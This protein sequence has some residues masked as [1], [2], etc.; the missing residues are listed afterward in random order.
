[1]PWRPLRRIAFAVA[2]HPFKAT[3]PADLPLVVGDELYI[4]E[5]GGKNSSWCRGYLVA[6]P[7]IVAGLTSAKGQTLE[8][9]VFSGIFPKQCVEIRE[10]MEQADGQAE[11]P[12]ALNGDL[13]KQ[14]GK[15][16]LENEQEDHELD[17]AAEDADE[18][19]SDDS[20]L[21]EPLALNGSLKSAKPTYVKTTEMEVRDMDSKRPR[22]A[23]TG[24][25]FETPRKPLPPVPLLKIG[26]ETPLLLSEPLVDEEASCLREWHSTKLHELLL[27]RRYRDLSRLGKRVQRADLCRRQLLHTVLAQP[28]ATNLRERTVWDLVNGNKLVGDEV[29]VRD[30]IQLGRL[31]TGSDDPI[32]VAK[33]QSSMSLLDKPPTQSMDVNNLHHLL[34]ELKDTASHSSDTVIMVVYIC[35]KR[36]EERMKFLSETFQFTIKTG[37][38]HTKSALAKMRTLFLNLTSLDIGE[39]A[40]PEVQV[41]LVVRIVTRTTL[42]ANP[43]TYPPSSSGDASSRP[44]SSLENDRTHS[45]KGRRSLMWSQKSPPS[46]RQKPPHIIEKGQLSASHANGPEL[47]N[48]DSTETSAPSKTQVIDKDAGI[49]VLHLTKAMLEDNHE[50]SLTVNVWSPTNNEPEHGSDQPEAIILPFLQDHLPSVSG[51]FDFAKPVDR[52]K[53]TLHSFVDPKADNLIRIRPTLLQHVHQTPKAGFSGAPT[54]P[55]SDIY[56]TLVKPNFPGQSLFAHHEKGAIP[57]PGISEMG[58]M[59]LTL[60]VRKSSGVRV[61]NC[62]FISSNASGLTAWRTTAISKHRTWSQIIKL[63]IPSEDVP[64]CHIIMSL[65]NFPEFPFALS[66][67]P[68][69]KDGAFIQDGL[70]ML[71]LHEYNKVTAGTVDTRGAYLE[72][73]WDAKSKD[74]ANRESWSSHMANLQIDTFLCSTEFSQDQVLL[75]IL[76]WKEAADDRL[77]LLLRQMV[78]V[79]EIEIV[80][81]VSDTL[82][83]LFSILVDRSGNDEFEDLVFNALVTVLSI[84]HDRRFHLD[85]LIDEYAESRFNYPFATP[86]LLRSYL[87]LIARRADYQNSRQ[88]RATL[89]VGRQIIKF[90][91]VARKQQKAKEAGIGITNN[92]AA[93]VRD[94]KKIF[95]ALEEQM[96]DESPSLIGNKTLILQHLHTWLPELLSCFSHEDIVN[97]GVSFVDACSN[98]GGKL[99]MHKLVLIW[100]FAKLAASVEPELRS[101][102]N[103]K[104][105]EWLDPYWGGAMEPDEQYREQVRLC[106]SVVALRNGDYGD[107]TNTFFI[108]TIQSYHSI[109]ELGRPDTNHFSLLFPSTYPFPSR[110][111]N[112]PRNY[113]EAL[114]ELSALKATFAREELLKRNKLVPF[115]VLPLLRKALDMNMSIIR[116]EAFPE[117]WLTLYVYQHRI[118]FKNLEYVAQ[119]MMDEHLPPPEDASKFDMEMWK[120]L[121]LAVLELVRSNTL[122]L[123]MLPD[124][125]RRAVWKIVG[126]IRQSGARLLRGIWDVIGWET[127]TDEKRQYGLDRLGGYQVQYVPS[128]VGPILELCLSVHE[129]LRGCAVEILQSMII[130][131]WSLNED[132]VVIQTEMIYALD[133]LFKTKNLGDSAQDRFFIEHLSA[134]F[135]PYSAAEENALWQATDS[136]LEA[137]DRLLDLLIAVHAPDQHE[138][139]RIMNTLKL[140]RF[141]RDLHKDDIFIGYVHQLAT[142]EVQAS[143]FREAGLALKLHADLYTWDMSESVEELKSPDFPKQTAFERKESLYF[144]MIKYFEE[145]GAWG[146]ALDCYRELASQYEKISFDFA[147]L[148]RTQRSTARI[149]E[150]IARGAGE[151]SRYFRVVFRGLGFPTT[152]RGRAFIYEGTSSERLVNFTDRL[153][154]Q[155]PS[156]QVS[157]RADVDNAEGQFLHI[158]TVSPHRELNHPVYQQSKVPLS[159]KEFLISS[160]P[161]EFSVT[162]KRHSPKTGMHEQWVEKTIYVTEEKFPTILRRSLI[163]SERHES[164]SPLETAIDRTVRKTFELAIL[165]R[166]VQEGDKLSRTQMLEAIRSSVDPASD[167]SVSQYRVILSKQAGTAANARNSST[168]YSSQTTSPTPQPDNN[169]IASLQTALL[170]F[171]SILKRSLSDLVNTPYKAEHRQFTLLFNNTFAPE[172]ATLNT[173]ATQTQQSPSSFAIPAPE[174]E[175]VLPPSNLNLSS[176]LAAQQST[177]NNESHIPPISPAAAEAPVVPSSRHSFLESGRHRLNSLLRRSVTDFEPSAHSYSLLSQ[178]QHGGGPGHSPGQARPSG[179]G[180]G[181]TPS[182]S[183]HSSAPGGAGGAGLNDIHSEGEEMPKSSYSYG[184]DG[185]SG[186]AGFGGFDGPNNYLIGSP[187]SGPGSGGG[188]SFSFGAGS[189]GGGMSRPGR[190]ELEAS[191]GRRYGGGRRPSG[192]GRLGAALDGSALG[193]ATAGGRSRMKPSHTAPP[194][195][196]SL[197]PSAAGS[198]RKRLSTTFGISR[199][200]SKLL[201]TP[202]LG[203][204]PGS[205]TGR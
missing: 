83:A 131:E 4:I 105:A 22:T 87:R 149:H 70:H 168:T 158:T 26:D 186:R 109:R 166:R 60:E 53:I 111:T 140:M 30:P 175:L 16:E 181:F 174:Q 201:G 55:R 188:D 99:V 96:R 162:A 89:K 27:S 88:L 183:I 144:E 200:A 3:E 78:F 141:L 95:E 20:S 196:S 159:T 199:K 14:H 82:D 205:R 76:K 37:E 17:E 153:L 29:I 127:D 24:D 103:V 120:S 161:N 139:L 195:S 137:I 31:L 66:W 12:A 157:S 45:L 23:D 101:K 123:E 10:E 79:P 97:I 54:K 62:I 145:A 38:M 85:P 172:L 71:L 21:G 184:R 192:G 155:H 40:G 150:F 136:L 118:I 51:Y 115:D 114:I 74:G 152:L 9:R 107:Q 6:P 143:N 44:G 128:L 34:F 204:P 81:L 80:K 98:V 68:L 36:P 116:G 50:T 130:S 52:I 8:A 119:Y 194:L 189:G 178:S 112:C 148:A 132:L 43:V 7:S 191:G 61:E 156:A 63:V 177:H 19:L 28:E 170:D 13:S 151:S 2:I 190:A 56:L 32:E 15:A 57:I 165:Q 77:L 47:P 125:K 163:V 129:G 126:D 176:N 121:L 193:T 42:P 187:G 104:V 1:M 122:A 110:S 48:G 173:H 65:A 39:A 100:N 185:G 203:P 46:N 33:L 72:L 58:N 5:V 69:W 171:T 180:E 92:E 59:Q 142:V 138:S 133:E 93:F 147:K 117:T 75:G 106:C 86:C 135:K 11:V 102:V 35:S 179:E 94:F 64:N 197:N 90:I 160:K 198:I 113:D 25:D 169:L 134:L 108:K 124:Q 41:Y 202:A 67:M 167:S 18:E 154:Q 164:L 49:A 91:L 73:G 84:V 146:C 182:F